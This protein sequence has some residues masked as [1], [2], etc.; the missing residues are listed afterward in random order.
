MGTAGHAL[1]ESRAVHQVVAQLFRQEFQDAH[2]RH[3]QP[4]RPA[5]APRTRTSALL[6]LQRMKVP[7]KLLYFTTRTTSCPSPRT[8]SWWWKTM[9]DWLA[10]YLKI[11]PG[12]GPADPA[13]KS[14]APDRSLPSR[15]HPVSQDVPEIGQA[16]TA[17]QEPLFFILEQFF[18]PNRVNPPS[19]MR[20]YPTPST[21]A[22][23][24]ETD[25]IVIS[26]FLSSAPDQSRNEYRETPPERAR[27]GVLQPGDRRVSEIGDSDDELRPSGRIMSF[28]KS[29]K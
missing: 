16:N 4:E 28:A 22:A 11:G 10:V 12:R 23:D 21:R 2:A 24:L 29:R 17:G 13:R 5:R 15:G 19:T 14:A 25:P 3:P 8:P 9:L 20:S 1:D 18:E 27:H 6:S 26:R 7:S